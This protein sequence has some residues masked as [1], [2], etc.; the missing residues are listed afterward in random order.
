MTP[1]LSGRPRLFVLLLI[2][3]A[4]PAAV[5][6]QT[7][8]TIPGQNLFV[9][10]TLQDIYLWYRELPD[11]NP[12]LFDSPEAYL[13]AVRFRPLDTSFSYI[14]TESASDAFF[15]DSQFIGLGI[16]GRAGNLWCRAVLPHSV[17]R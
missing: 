9:R 2:A 8:C 11:P 13:E 10:N 7:D 5:R 1:K 12:A 6:A 14:T 17:S 4:V 15:S 3:L 16:H